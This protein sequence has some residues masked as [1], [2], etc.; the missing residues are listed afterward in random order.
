VTGLRAEARLARPIS[1]NVRAGGGLPAGA[2]EAAEALA[3]QGVRALM[4]FGLAGGLDPA[5]AAGMLVVPERIVSAEGMWA[6]DP[7]LTEAC[8]GATADSLFAGPEIVAS[9][10]E[11]AALHRLTGAAAIDLESGEVAA[12]ASRHGLPFVVVRAI[13]DPAERDLPPAALAALNSAGAI[14]V[15]RVLVS[16]LRA[17]WQ[18]PLLLALARDAAAARRALAAVAAN[19]A[20]VG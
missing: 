9:A 16:L 7:A 18:L 20:Q 13:C 11:K 5:F 12:A 4:S 3:G 19:I 2:R 17:P 6:A 14:G 1:A 8:G 15:G 10:W